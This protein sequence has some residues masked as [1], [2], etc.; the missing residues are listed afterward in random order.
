LFSQHGDGRLRNVVDTPEV[1]LELGTEVLIISGLDGRDV[2][3]ASVVDD[4]V[5][6]AEPL[7]RLVDGRPRGGGVGDIQGQR[8]SAIRVGRDEVVQLLWPAC[9]GGDSIAR[10]ERGPRQ[11]SPEAA[12][13]T[14]DE[15]CLR[16]GFSKTLFR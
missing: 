10:L 15:P 12:G 7:A 11:R 3:V 6:P 1:G 2:G 16:H 14:G 9:G 13:G 5:E 8:V 4:D